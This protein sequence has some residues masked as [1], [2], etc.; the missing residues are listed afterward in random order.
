MRIDEAVDRFL[1]SLTLERG[2]SE[3]TVRAYRQ[4]LFKFSTFAEALGITE[5]DAVTIETLRD[6]LWQRK[7]EGCTAST[8]ARITA[9]LRSFFRWADET[10]PEVSDL[11]SRLRSPKVGRRLPRVLTRDQMNEILSKAQKRADTGDPIEIRDAAIL[12]LLYATALRVSELCTLTLADIDQEQRTV[13]V[14]GKG[15]KER[16]V[17]YG[18]PAGRAISRYLAE[19]RPDTDAKEFFVSETA[20]PLNTRTVYSLVSKV[21]EDAPG[22]G[23]RGPH[24]FRHT[25]ATHL[26]DGGADLRVVQEMLGHAN[27]S[28]TQVYTHVSADRLAQTYKMAH[29]RA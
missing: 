22:G 26:L 5:L 13:R 8:L 16:V 11:G 24:T 17:P 19:A 4:D 20:R 18:V 10:I 1:R 7:Q 28:S 25:A 3:N 6:W 12:E 27:L 2:L 15:N 21:L 14:I 29:P 9:T 23:P